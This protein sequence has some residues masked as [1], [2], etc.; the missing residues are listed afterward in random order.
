M[1]FPLNIW[2]CLFLV[3][4]GSA[5]GLQSFGVKIG[6]EK[7][8]QGLKESVIRTHATGGKDRFA[9]KK[10]ELDRRGCIVRDR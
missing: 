9:Q 2:Q 5:N 10:F 3:L 1:I 6:F 4:L 8:P 7:L